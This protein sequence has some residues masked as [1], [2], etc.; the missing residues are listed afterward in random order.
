M[1][2]WLWMIGRGNGKK[3]ER[4]VKVE[5]E[6]VWEGVADWVGAECA[7][8]WDAVEGVA[9]MPSIRCYALHLWFYEYNWAVWKKNILKWESSPP[10]DGIKQHLSSTHMDFVR[11][12]VYNFPAKNVWTL[13]SFFGVCEGVGVWGRVCV[14]VCVCVWDCTINGYGVRTHA[15][16]PPCGDSLSLWGHFPW[17]HNQNR[18]RKWHLSAKKKA[19]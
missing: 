11:H 15:S 12:L 6:L 5:Q 3:A 10:Y 9:N 13:K 17:P 8:R 14:R 19:R 1:V 7:W 4:K 2:F 18:D 16:V